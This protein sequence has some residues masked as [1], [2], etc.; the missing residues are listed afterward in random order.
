M[1]SGQGTP[2]RYF[3]FGAACSLVEVSTPLSLRCGSCWLLSFVSCFSGALSR[4]VSMPLQ[5]D[6]LTGDFHI[7]SSN[8]VMDLGCSLNPVIDV[9]QVW[10]VDLLLPSPPA[11]HWTECCALC[12]LLL[13]MGGVWVRVYNRLKVRLRKAWVCSRWRSSCGAINSTNGSSPAR[14]SREVE[15]RII[16]LRYPSI[17]THTHTHTHVRVYILSGPGAYKLPGFND[18]P[19][20]FRINLLKVLSR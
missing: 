20:D 19:I 15:R 11:F 14:S 2:F 1:R 9:G 3:T 5:I 8:V 12:V 10:A 13:C 16:T 7:L 18:V 6:T 4:G 17:H